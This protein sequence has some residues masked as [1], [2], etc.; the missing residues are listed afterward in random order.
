[1]HVVSCPVSHRSSARDLAQL[2]PIC[3]ETAYVIGGLYGNLE[4]LDA[5]ETLAEREAADREVRPVL[6][7]NGDFHW[8]DADPRWFREV[9]RRVLVHA[10]CLGNVE[11]ELMDPQPGAGCG[12]AYPRSVSQETVSRSNAIMSRLQHMAD[13]HG[14]ELA[15]L[16]GLPKQARIQCGNLRVGVVHGDPA[17]VSG[18]GLELA[19]MPIPGQTSQS[20]QAWFEDAEV[21]VL[22]SSHT[23]RCFAQDFPRGQAV[24]NN[25]AA[26]MPNFLGDHRLVITRISL[27]PS[28]LLPESEVLYSRTYGNVTVSALAVTWDLPGFLAR[29]DRVWPDGTPASESYRSRIVRGPPHTLEEAHRLG[30]GSPGTERC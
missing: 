28:A 14:I 30:R 12:C 2:E 25:G 23:C 21:D 11:L 17:S 1:M 27:H 19:A 29:F 5:I 20:L 22:A 7:F 13:Q 8:F 24:F 15:G 3:A 16:R 10:P 9:Q 4:A 26:G 18:W 6:V